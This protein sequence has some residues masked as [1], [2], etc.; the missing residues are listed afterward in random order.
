MKNLQPAGIQL[1]LIT[2]RK[3][4]FYQEDAEIVSEICNDLDGQIFSR[5]SLVMNSADDTTAFPGPSLIGITVLTDPLPDSF[6]E[7]ERTSKTVVTQISSETFQYKRLQ[8]MSKVEG[9]RGLILSELEFASGEHL[10][11]EFSEVA[12]SGLGERNALQHLFARPSLSCRRLDCGFS[13]WNTSHIVS[14]SHYPKLEAPSNAWAAESL[15]EHAQAD[16]KIVTML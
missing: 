13:I 3:R 4:L 5:A 15:A 6:L 16:G 14:W 9:V 8:L 7:R 10:F 12:K 11:L 2:G 1:H